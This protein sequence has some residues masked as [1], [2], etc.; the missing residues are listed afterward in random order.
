MI[1]GALDHGDCPRVAHGKAL[2][3]HAPEIALPADGPVEHGVADDNALLR[4]DAG[5][6]I[7]AHDQLAPGEALADVVVGLTDEVEADAVR[8]PGAETLPGRAL[9]GKPYA[10]LGQAGMA[11]A[12]GDLAREHRPGGAI[13]IAD[14]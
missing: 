9:E 12:F 2:T 10:I 4:R 3:R 14:R 8:Q 7:R 11:V 5:A 13:A 6:G 1:A